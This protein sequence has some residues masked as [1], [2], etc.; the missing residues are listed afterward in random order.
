MPEDIEEI[1]GN[2][3]NVKS[4]LEKYPGASEDI[5]EALPEPRGL[6]LSTPVYFDSN[7][8]HDQVTCLLV[9][10]VLSFFWSMPIN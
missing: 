9:S 1:S 7:H 10:G 3:S 8:D 2:G 5:D 4:W 6:S